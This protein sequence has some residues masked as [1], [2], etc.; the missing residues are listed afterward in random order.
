[1]GKKAAFSQFAKPSLKD[2]FKFW[3]TPAKNATE[4][5]GYSVRVDDWRYTAWFQFDGAR[6]RPQVNDIIGRE[7][8]SHAGDDGDLDFPGENVN[9][10][11]DP[12]NK[13]TVSRLHNMI[14]DYIQ[15]WPVSTSGLVSEGLVV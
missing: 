15:I 8:Y 4:I 12:G 10:V 1:M 11:D 6:L 9:V 13:D 7:L 14:L 5:M 3:P 2:P